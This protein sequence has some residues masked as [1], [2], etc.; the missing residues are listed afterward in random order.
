MKKTEDF[1][2]TNASLTLCASSDPKYF[3]KIKLEKKC[4]KNFR[5]VKIL[6]I[7]VIIGMLYA[8]YHH[9]GYFCIY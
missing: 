7:Q 4:T 2:Q 3:K 6:K 8:N 5:K 9:Q 1:V